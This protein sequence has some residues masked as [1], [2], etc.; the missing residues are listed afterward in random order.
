MSR[1]LDKTVILTPAMTVTIIDKITIF[2]NDVNKTI[3]YMYVELLAILR[4]VS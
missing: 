2:C 3:T 4:Y 1:Y